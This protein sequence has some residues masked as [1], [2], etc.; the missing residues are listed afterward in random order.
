MTLP[1]LSGLDLKIR[2]HAAHSDVPVI[3][4]TAHDTEELRRAAR[5]A[6]FFRKPGDSQALLDAIRSMSPRPAPPRLSAPLPARH[7]PDL[8]P[9]LGCRRPDG[10]R[11][12]VTSRAP[13]R[14]PLG[15]RCIPTPDQRTDNTPEIPS[16]TRTQ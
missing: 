9:R 5:A 7:R 1:G 16:T 6:G 10:K 4:L 2:L 15:F 12:L 3:F 13:G 8:S 14:S 11:L